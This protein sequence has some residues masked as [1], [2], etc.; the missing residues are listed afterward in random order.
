MSL[1]ASVSQQAMIAAGGAGSTVFSD[2]FNRAD[3]NL[4]A[5][6]DWDRLD[7]AAGAMGVRSNQ[8]ATLSTTDTAYACPDVGDADQYAEATWERN[9]AA[10]YFLAVRVQDSDNFIGFRRHSDDDIEIYVRESGSFTLVDRLEDIGDHYTSLGAV[11]STYRLE[12][13]GTTAR[14]L[15]NGHIVAEG[16]I[17]SYSPSANRTGFIART[18]LADPAFDNF[19]AGP[20]TDGLASSDIFLVSFDGAN[21][22]TTATDEGVNSHSL[23]FSGGAALD[24]GD[25]KFG[26]TSLL[27]DG[28]DDVVT[29][30]NAPTLE[31]ADTDFTIEMWVKRASSQSGLHGLIMKRGTSTGWALWIDSNDPRFFVWGCGIDFTSSAALPL[32]TWAHL[33]VTKEG[34]T[35]KIWIDG[36]ERAS[37]TWTSSGEY[38][39]NSSDLVIGDDNTASGR[40]FDGRIQEIRIT[41]GLARYT[42]AFTPPAA[43]FVL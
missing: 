5:S 36:V 23:T 17:G 25:A 10:A 2:D 22:A 13:V 15:I 34:S 12:V 41:M 7:G 9:D 30:A 16:S 29:V 20:L 6:A 31:L 28:S 1:F 38:T 37:D 21:G 11:G 35:V 32:N 33:A 18:S 14:A 43:S 27:L 24:N 4:E 42:A 19:E 8:L 26:S 40:H 39:T 3:E